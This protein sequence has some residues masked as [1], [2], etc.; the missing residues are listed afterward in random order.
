MLTFGGFGQRRGKGQIRGKG[1]GATVPLPSQPYF[2]GMDNADWSVT[3]IYNENAYAQ[4][5]VRNVGDGQVPH[6]QVPAVSQLKFFD[7]NASAAIGGKGRGR[8][9]KARAKR[10]MGK[11]INLAVRGPGFMGQN[12]PPI[13]YAAPASHMTNIAGYNHT[14][15]GSTYGAGM[16]AI[17]HMQ[18]R[19]QV[20]RGGSWQ[21]G[22]AYG[23]VVTPNIIPW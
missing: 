16:H 18:Q 21:G 23:A 6:V 5:R 15:D 11:R 7:Q 17:H 22:N 20:K 14:S 12:E 3:P 8:K 4:L 19:H 1:Q 10:G 9:G 2:P 13:N